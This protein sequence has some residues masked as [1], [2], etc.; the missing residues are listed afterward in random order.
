MNYNE[1]TELINT[2]DQDAV[3]AELK[4]NR[5]TV[6]PD[7]AESRRQINPERHKVMD[8]TYRPDKEIMVRGKNGDIE[9]RYTEP[10]GRSPLALQSLIVKRAVAFL[11]GNPVKLTADSNETDYTDVLS[12]V[13]RVFADVKINPINR[14]V[15]RILMTY[16]EVA[17]YWY[18]QQ[19][20]EAADRY[21]FKS[22]NKMRVSV[23]SAENGDILYPFFDDNKDMV[24]FSREY[25]VKKGDKVTTYF[26]TYTKDFI[27]KWE[28]S[29]GNTAPSE[30]YP[31]A[32][33]L[34]K[35][36][37]VYAYQ[38]KTEWQ[39]VQTLIERLELLLSNFADTNDYHASPK[40]FCQGK[41]NGF[42]KKAE[43]GTILQGDPGST[44]QYLTW[45]QA[46][47]SV[48]LEIET[49]LKM[50][51]TITQT[52]D[53]SFDNVKGIGAISG[54]AL[55]LLFMDS[56]LKV[57]EKAEIF[58]MYLQRRVNI[59]LAFLSKMNLQNA[60]FTQKCK[61]I[62]I[63]PE[64]QPYMIEDD[65]TKIANIAAAKAANIISPE[66]GVS[67]LNWVKD[68]NEELDKINS[69]RAAESVTDLMTPME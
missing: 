16:R 69:D 12:A 2:A 61:E 60:D 68:V 31:K 63:T 64:I 58:E 24:A 5:L 43:Q 50:I 28:T 65:T 19:D 38:P 39:D 45:S 6:Q 44:V 14:E 25:S 41:I 1:L 62:I 48:R 22:E 33:P 32:N 53:I 55:R 46:P 30:G 66:T 23:F 51:Y 54:T 34:G 9:R 7:V 49:L 27:Y 26:E 52:P 4:N 18:I 59:V 3:I 40:I 57:Q 42:S 29:D 67:R 36:P 21:G 13:K 11:F 8:T 35:I 56:H 20:E 10:V 17:E 15:A 47:E 37:I